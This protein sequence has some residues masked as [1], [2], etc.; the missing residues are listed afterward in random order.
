[1]MEQMDLKL[2]GALVTATAAELNLIDGVTATAA[3]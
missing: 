1:M 2:G 3:E